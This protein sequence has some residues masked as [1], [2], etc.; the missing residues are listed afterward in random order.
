MKMR[1]SGSFQKAL[2]RCICLLCAGTMSPRRCDSVSR[3]VFLDPGASKDG[4]A[5]KDIIIKRSTD[6]QVFE[7]LLLD[8][9]A[10]KFVLNT[11]ATKVKPPRPCLF[12]RE[13][14]I[15]VLEDYVN[16]EGFKTILISLNANRLVP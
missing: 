8:K 12:D 9:K 16:T 7:E 15:Q 2:K 4:T 13:S 6:F 14:N 11:T 10:G 5:I 1:F 3:R